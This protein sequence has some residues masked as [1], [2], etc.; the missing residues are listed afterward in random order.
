VDGT[1]VA[2][3]Y[4]GFEGDEQWGWWGPAPQDQTSE[5][6]APG[7]VL[8]GFP[9]EKWGWEGPFFSEQSVYGENRIRPG[10]PGNFRVALFFWLNSKE[11]Q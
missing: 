3:G 1:A 2:G 8:P 4:G 5:E 11:Q 9:K 6:A 10:F 7:Q